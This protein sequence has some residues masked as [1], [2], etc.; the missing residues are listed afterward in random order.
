MKTRL[1]TKHFAARPFADV[2]AMARRLLKIA[3]TVEPVQDRRIHIEKINEPFL[4]EGGTT[5][6]YGAAHI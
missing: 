1:C 2:A 5:A 6:E 3:H 4:K